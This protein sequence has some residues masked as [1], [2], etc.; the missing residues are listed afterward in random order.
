MEYK[1][2]RLLRYLAH[3]RQYPTSLK[4][5]AVVSGLTEEQT[6]EFIGNNYKYIG[7]FTAEGKIHFPTK[8][9][10]GEKEGQLWQ[11]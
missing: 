6:R 9:F 2:E 4:A 7:L 8:T 3:I 5:A 1:V 11:G 10:S